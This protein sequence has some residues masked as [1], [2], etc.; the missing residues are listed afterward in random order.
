ML[1]GRAAR[2]EKTNSLSNCLTAGYYYQDGVVGTLLAKSTLIFPWRTQW[3]CFDLSLERI[4]TMFVRFLPEY[5][6][7]WGLLAN[8]K[9]NLS[10]TLFLHC[11]LRLIL[12]LS[13]KR[14]TRTST[15]YL[16]S[17]MYQ[18][19]N[20]EGSL[21]PFLASDKATRVLVK[22]SIAFVKRGSIAIKRILRRKIERNKTKPETSFV[23]V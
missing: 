13:L 23:Q 17:L 8:E 4:F 20:S 21:C 18:L 1:V 15:L 14:T 12:A 22:W 16:F 9:E 7:I 19:I 2:H 3:K 6:A 5:N 11:F 10:S